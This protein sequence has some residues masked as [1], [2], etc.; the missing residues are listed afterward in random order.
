MSSSN[1]FSS[2]SP[3]LVKGHTIHPGLPRAMS[4]TFLSLPPYTSDASPNQKS[5]SSASLPVSPDCRPLHTT[6]LAGR[7]TRAHWLTYQQ[8]W[9]SPPWPLQSE[10]HSPSF[11]TEE[12]VK[13]PPAATPASSW[14]PHGPL[15]VLRCARLTAHGLL[16]GP[17]PARAAFL[18][19]LLVPSGC[20]SFLCL[21]SICWPQDPG[22]N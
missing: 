7:A 14:P 4:H 21:Q 2:F 15:K 10:A 9:C 1:L 8:S 19:S 11:G 12:L 13:H 5:L 6:P 22:R 17:V 18:V 16:Q 3:H 20:L